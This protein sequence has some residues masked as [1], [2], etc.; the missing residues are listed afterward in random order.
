MSEKI[1]VPIDGSESSFRALDFAV[2]IAKVHQSEL[3][4]LHVIPAGSVPEG[5]KEWARAERDDSP[6]AV[7]Y[8]Q[9]IADNVL[10]GAESRA[11]ERGARNLHRLVE[12]GDPTKRI[13]EE[14]SSQGADVIVMG[15][16]GLSDLQGLVM[17]SVAHKVTHAAECTVVT[18][19]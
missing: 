15:T 8:E 6:P 19:R 16:R 14:A 2:D 18:V 7:L 17:G 1:L 3:Y 4:L 12:R 9:A 10:A 11:A 5:L 13:L